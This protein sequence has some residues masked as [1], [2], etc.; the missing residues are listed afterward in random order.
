MQFC[1]KQSL[2]CIPLPGQSLPSAE[3]AGLL[4]KRSRLVTPKPQGSLQADQAPQGDH[5][6]ST[7]AGNEVDNLEYYLNHFA[8][9]KRKIFKPVGCN[10]IDKSCLRYLGPHLRNVECYCECCKK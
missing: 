3:G 4:Q 1:W 8:F 5:D 9:E 7:R 6:P 2:V 10:G